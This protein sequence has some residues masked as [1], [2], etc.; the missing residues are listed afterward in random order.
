MTEREPLLT[1]DFVMLGIADL[2]YFTSIGVAIL[3]LPLT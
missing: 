1:R 2:A 3:A